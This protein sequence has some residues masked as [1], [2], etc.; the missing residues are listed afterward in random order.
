MTP[1][2]KERLRVLKRLSNSTYGLYK[3]CP[4]CENN[5]W[6]WYSSKSIICK[7]CDSVY[8]IENM[9]R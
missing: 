9:I 7:H 4:Y 1:D 5:D 6:A 3:P 2:E 8:K